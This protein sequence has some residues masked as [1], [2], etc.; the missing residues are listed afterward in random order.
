[1]EGLKEYFPIIRKVVSFG[2][3]AL[4]VTVF[5]VPYLWMILSSFK[6]TGE[7]FRYLSPVSV[8]TFIPQDPT[9]Q[10]YRDIFDA[11][12]TGLQV[13]FERYIWNTLFTAV[14]RVILTLGVSALIA[15]A[16]AR[17][18]FPGRNLVFIFILSTMLVPFETVVVPTYL[19]VRSLGLENTYTAL[20]VPWGASPFVVFLLR[21][22]FAEIPRELDEAAIID[23]ASRL[24]IF[25]HVVLPNTR[26]ALV[27]GGLVI[28]LWGWD[29]FFWPLVVMQDATKQVIQVAI[30]TFSTPEQLFWGR[31]FA[32]STLSSIPVLILFLALQRFYLRSVVSS[33][34]KG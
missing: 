5:V 30:A 34:L 16:L 10:N 7:I 28:F 20:I 29:E 1:M 15:Y 33:G 14:S 12:A 3:G 19:I 26:P 23:G 13:G 8:K 4:I 22:F 24:Q 18:E 25:W 9:L 32:A 2:L 11:S 6:H 27:T 31:I 17:I 21:Q